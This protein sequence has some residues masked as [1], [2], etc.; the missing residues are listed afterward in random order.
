MYISINPSFVCSSSIYQAYIYLL[1]HLCTYL[2]VKLVN[3]GSQYQYGNEDHAEF[4]CVVSREYPQ[5]RPPQLS[6]LCALRCSREFTGSKLQFAFVTSVAEQTFFCIPSDGIK[7]QSGEGHYIGCNN[8]YF[9]M[10]RG[11]CI[12]GR[13]TYPISG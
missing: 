11:P 5:V 8:E 4:L 7:L 12:Y 2:C 9:S 10:K 6:W 13:K 3:I 1:I